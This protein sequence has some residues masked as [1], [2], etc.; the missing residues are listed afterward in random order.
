AR[1]K[2][3]EKAYESLKT[4]SE[5]FCLP[6]SFHANGDQSGTGKS[7]F[8]YR[9]FTLEGNFAFASSLQEMLIQSNS[10]IIELFPAVPP[11]WKDISFKKL[12]AEGAFLVDAVFS[13]GLLNKVVIYS[14]KGGKV[15]VKNTFKNKKCICNKK[16]NPDILYNEVIEIKMEP[17]ERIVLSCLK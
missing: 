2:N 14:E 15:K 3:G 6:N 11:E 17:K 7:N 16:I 12:R 9:P 5:C 10:G 4:F 1:A 13:D 8:T